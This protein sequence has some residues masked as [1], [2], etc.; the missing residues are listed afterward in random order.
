MKIRNGF[1]SNSS[2]SSFL[3]FGISDVDSIN[4]VFNALDIKD[5]EG[6]TQQIEDYEFSYPIENLMQDKYDLKLFK[7]DYSGY[8]AL[9]NVVLGQSDLMNYTEFQNNINNTKLQLEELSKLC[10]KKFDYKTA[11]LNVPF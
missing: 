6:N 3:V 7:D 8:F 2:S 5:S 11:I 4:Q 1:V 10:N 9:G